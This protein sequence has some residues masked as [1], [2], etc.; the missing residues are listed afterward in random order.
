MLHRNFVTLGEGGGIGAGIHETLL[1]IRGVLA[2]DS[3]GGEKLD[4][5]MF[6]PFVFVRT[7]GARPGGLI[8]IVRVEPINSV[9]LL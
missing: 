2:R 5:A 3:T 4:A 7:S 1:Q 8:S 6:V 9:L